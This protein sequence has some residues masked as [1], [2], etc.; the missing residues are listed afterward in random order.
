VFSDLIHEPPTTSIATC[1]RPKLPSLP[2]DDFP[3]GALQ[4][5]SVAVFW[6]PPDQK[7]AWR[8]AVEEHGLTANFALYSASES[9]EVAITPPPRPTLVATETER[10]TERERYLS[11][12][13]MLVIGI[14]TLLGLIVLLPLV[15]VLVGRLR[16]RNGR[17]PQLP[18]SGNGRPTPVS[19]RRPGAP[20][21]PN[22]PRPLGPRPLTPPHTQRQ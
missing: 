15:L 9:T 2:P 21:P 14:G 7:L 12:G 10:Q 1:Q 13:K 20:V 8:R 5:V 4:D 3:W 22:G 19:A 17:S 16:Q 18:A 6:A 11:Y